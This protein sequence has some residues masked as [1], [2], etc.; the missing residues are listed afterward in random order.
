MNR[1]GTF[2]TSL[3]PHAQWHS[4]QNVLQKKKEVFMVRFD[5]KTLQVKK[6][7]PFHNYQNQS[8]QQAIFAVMK[9]AIHLFTN[10]F[11]K[12]CLVFKGG[13][14]PGTRS[15]MST[16]HIRWWF[17]KYCAGGVLKLTTMVRK[18]QPLTLKALRNAS[19]ID[20]QQ[21]R[22]QIWKICGVQRHEK[23]RG[24]GD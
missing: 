23:A 11:I 19:G 6:S 24:E 22:T 17:V 20:Q 12:I 21:A 1:E 10:L 3:Y 9:I 18:T 4:G 5:E 14:I 16:F 15:C 13:C 8:Q 7:Q 2:K